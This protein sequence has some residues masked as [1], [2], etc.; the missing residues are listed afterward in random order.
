M[1]NKMVLICCRYST[2]FRRRAVFLIVQHHFIEYRFRL[3]WVNL[4]IQ[5]IQRMNSV[6]ED[7]DSGSTS[8]QHPFDGINPSNAGYKI[9]AHSQQLPLL[10]Q[11][12]AP[13]HKHKKFLP[14]NISHYAP[15]QL[16]RTFKFTTEI[17]IQLMHAIWAEYGEQIQ[18]GI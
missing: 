12:S 7:R 13:L 16:T 9:I 8:I 10:I 18:V 15:K 1:A 6:P 4:A 11:H 14:C 2:Y 5:S 3:G 17:E